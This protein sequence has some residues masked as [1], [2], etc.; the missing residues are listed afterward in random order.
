MYVD[1]DATGAN[2][3]SSWAN[4]FNY[5]QDAL[6]T[7]SAEDEIRIAEGTYKPNQGLLPFSDRRRDI[8]PGEVGR[9]AAFGLKDGLIVKGGFAGFGESDPNE[10]NPEIY[11]TILSGDLDGNDVD[12]NDPRDL[13]DEPTR[14]ENSYNVLTIYGDVSNI[15][16]DGLIIKCATKGGLVNIGGNP[17][18]SNCVFTKNSNDESGGAIV[19]INGSMVL[20]YCRFAAN[21]AAQH[22]GAAYSDNGNDVFVECNF[23]ENSALDGTG[24]VNIEGSLELES[25]TFSHHST[26]SPLSANKEGGGAIFIVSKKVIVKN[27]L[28]NE[29]VARYGGAMVGVADVLT[30]EGCVFKGNSAEIGG[31]IY[32]L[33]GGTITNSIF[34]DNQAEKGGAICGRCI[35]PNLIGCTL[36]GN[37][38]QNGNAISWYPC[39]D[40]SPF[41][42]SITNCI[43][44]NGGDE[45]DESNGRLFDNAITYS[46]IQDGW[47][48]E[49]N[50]DLD[51][52]FADTRNGDF[53]L[54]SQAGRWDSSRHSW[55]QDDV[56]SPCVDAGDPNSP[57]GHEPFPNGGV[58]NM[59]AYGGTPEASKSPTGLHAKYSGGTGE[60]NDPYLIYTAEQM[61]TIG[62][63]PNDWDKH[64]K[65]MADIDLSA[66]SG[67]DFNLIGESY[68]S[69]FN[70]LFD[71]NGHTI[72]Y[73]T[74]ADPSGRGIGLISHLGTSGCVRNLILTHPDV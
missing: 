30:L 16:L 56:T 63:D 44:R 32:D 39:L 72:Y 59:G 66:F 69:P 27:C 62:I 23:V 49:G 7:A 74:F 45:I 40:G 28:F 3:G 61:N 4:A 57:I 41:T 12:M 5:L 71:G 55:I 10:R 25:C 54:K 19:N 18:I 52:L 13:V 22:G 51:P 68:E 53:H 24:I 46:N 64:F 60:L 48:G 14:A 67:T 36:F 35:G 29:N 17:R 70:G 50:F 21:S 26:Y 33:R 38:A 65:L 8:I 20:T 58:V 37:S 15:V 47:P 1:G 31:A 43:L 9:L 6:I 73:F 42:M 11:K 2:D 34:A